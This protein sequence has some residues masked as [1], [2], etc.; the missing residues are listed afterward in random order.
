MQK[1][2]T[3]KIHDLTNFKE[4]V[5]RSEHAE[6]QEICEEVMEWKNN[7]YPDTNR[8]YK[9]FKTPIRYSATVWGAIF[10]VRKIP[11]YTKLHEQPLYLRN[12]VFKIEE[13]P[14]K[15]SKHW[16]KLPTK[17]KHGGIWL[18]ITVPR[19]YEAL[20]K[21]KLCDSKITKRGEDWYLLLTVKAKTQ[22][23]T[24]YSNI[25]AIDLGEKVM[26]T[27]CGRDNKPLFLGREVRGI[28]RHYAW[29]RKRLGN[30]KALA[31][32]KKVGSKEQRR[33]ND[34]LHKIARKIVDKAKVE[35]SVIV[36]GDLKGIRNSAKGK[37]KRFNRIV[38][39]MPY[40]K[41]T[42]FIEYKAEWE[43]I[44]TIKINERDTSHTCS[45]CGA[46]GKRP[47]QGLFK[48]PSC[49]YTVNADYN[50]AQNIKK[51][52]LEYISKDGASLTKPITLQE[53]TK[54]H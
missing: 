44:P 35:D 26:A 1:T 45:K 53:A 32:I 20:L 15:I 3:C 48:C 13:Q 9:L 42:Q 40:Y 46:K 2:I 39:N 10:T 7:D 31:T 21:H 54:C 25:L 28:R 24:S 19:K 23:K 52:F 12:D 38:S 47:H 22:I 4:E 8:P 5:L 29:L 34:S 43:G 50:G 36:L 37:G 30:K 27:V 6:Y 33:I 18:P 16:L 49:G 14:T 51:R 11:Q 17:Q 41:L